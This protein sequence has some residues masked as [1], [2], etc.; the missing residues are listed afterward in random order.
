MRLF[1]VFTLLVLAVLQECHSFQRL[2]PY[3]LLKNVNTRSSRS[4]KWIVLSDSKEI[5]VGS[6]AE[7]VEMQNKAVDLTGPNPVAK[8]VL[9]GKFEDSI[10]PKSGFT[11]K[12]GAFDY[13][14]LLAFP[15]M[16]ATLGFFFFFPFIAP[17]LAAL[18]LGGGPP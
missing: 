18:D 1:I 8:S 11:E 3:T 9:D 16:I 17:Q 12:Q 6:S 10:N 14:L 2:S 5:E 13:G 15:V 4:E 7:Q